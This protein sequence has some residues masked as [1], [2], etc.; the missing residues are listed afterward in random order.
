MKKYFFIVVIFCMFVF[1]FTGCSQN[2]QDNYS[3]KITIGKKS[4]Q[5]EIADTPAKLSRGLSGR[6]SLCPD[7]GMLFVFDKP[8]VPSFWMKDMKFP[9]DIIWI[10]DDQVIGIISDLPPLKSNAKPIYYHSP[11]PINYVIEVNS[12]WAQS[13]KIKIGDRVKF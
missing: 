13:R 6:E 11:Q 8:L 9:L 12:G 7:C 3:H 5:I 4:L 2:K 10:K 1:I